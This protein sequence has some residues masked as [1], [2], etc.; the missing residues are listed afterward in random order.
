MNTDKRTLEVLRKVPFFEG[1]S[2]S[3]VKNLVEICHARAIPKGD[4]LCRIGEPSN[5]MFVVLTGTVAIG[6]AQSTLLTEEAITTIGETGALT[7]EPRSVTVKAIT[8][9][10][11]LEI[12]RNSLGSMLK[13]DPSL[14]SRIYRSVM[15]SLRGK[16]VKATVKIDVLMKNADSSVL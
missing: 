6:T 10:N 13:S 16:L 5:S 8:D 4:N 2:P 11:V 1:L 15:M 12:N 3:Q 9:C 7:G 14:A